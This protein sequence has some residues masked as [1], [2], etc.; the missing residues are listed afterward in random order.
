MYAVDWGS[1]TDEYHILLITSFN[2]LVV[3]IVPGDA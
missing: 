3:D 1:R 2:L